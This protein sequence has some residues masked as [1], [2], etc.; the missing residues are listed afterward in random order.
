MSKKGNPTMEVCYENVKALEEAN[1]ILEARVAE[2]EARVAHEEADC[3]QVIDQR[4]R[5]HD[6]A[7]K[8]AQAI[9]DHMREDIGEHSNLNNPWANALELIDDTFCR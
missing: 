1:A 4:D 8:L 7:D 2:L 9:S 5:Y 3:L 6:W